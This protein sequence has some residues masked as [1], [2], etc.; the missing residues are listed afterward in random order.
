MS[1]QFKNMNTIFVMFLCAIILQAVLRNSPSGLPL[2]SDLD[3]VGYNNTVIMQ[4]ID[5]HGIN[6]TASN[7]YNYYYTNYY[8]T[9]GSEP[10]SNSNSRPDGALAKLLRPLL[11]GMVLLQP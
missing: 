11:G 7:T 8:E 4:Q 1:P 3:K 5:Q 10:K 9:S 6:N 2:D